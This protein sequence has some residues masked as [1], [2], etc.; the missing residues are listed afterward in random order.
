MTIDRISIHEE[1]NSNVK[2]KTKNKNKNIKPFFLIYNLIVGAWENGEPCSSIAPPIISRDIMYCFP[3]PLFLR[4][5]YELSDLK[6][7]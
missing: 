5:V 2:I 3:N 1:C 4:I 7:I 6:L